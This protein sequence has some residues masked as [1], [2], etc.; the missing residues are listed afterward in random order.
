MS[1]PARE[2]K[3]LLSC[4]PAPPDPLASR[5]LPKSSLPKPGLKGVRGPGSGPWARRGR[6]VWKKLGSSSP[7]RVP[8][9]A[10]TGL[11]GG[12]PRLEDEEESG[13]FSLLQFL[14]HPLLSNVA[15]S[16]SAP[17]PPSSQLVATWH[18]TWESGCVGVFVCCACARV[19]PLA[20]WLLGT[21][22]VLVQF[23]SPSN[24]F[25]PPTPSPP[26]RDP[27]RKK[28]RQYLGWGC[29]TPAP[30]LS[31]GED[32][33]AGRGVGGGVSLL[34]ARRAAGGVAELVV[35][36]EPAV[37]LPNGCW[38]GSQSASTPAVAGDLRL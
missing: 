27:D 2:C 3:M 13:T 15:P 6:A 33:L 25:C 37:L 23:R 21:G 8:S 35:E 34:R 12:E 16:N 1:S 5:S 26:P 4:P 24:H 31:R 10:G 18:W 38:C 17:P 7:P 36:S 19:L 29:V 14:R 11:P 32:P 30:A 20:S 22:T 9:P 28:R